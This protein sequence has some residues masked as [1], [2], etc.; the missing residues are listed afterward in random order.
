MNLGE[1]NLQSIIDFV[2]EEGYPDCGEFSGEVHG[3]GPDEIIFECG[4]VVD[5]TQW[6]DASKLEGN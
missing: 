2:Q 4:H 3:N 1:P 6:I 5:A